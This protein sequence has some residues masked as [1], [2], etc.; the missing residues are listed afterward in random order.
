MC[1][2]SKESIMHRASFHVL[3][4]AKHPFTCVC[5]RKT[6]LYLFAPA[7]HH[8]TQ[9]A[10]LKGHVSTS[11]HTIIPPV[12]STGGVIITFCVCK[13]V[14]IFPLRS[15]PILVTEE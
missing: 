12:V 2:V 11:C 8:L 6:L 1:V 9:L 15:S 5:F 3:A 7:K 13:H 4:L 14:L 10:F